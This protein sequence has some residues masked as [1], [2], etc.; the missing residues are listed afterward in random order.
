MIIG[1]LALT[2]TVSINT[3]VFEDVYIA[4]P[5]SKNANQAPEHYVNNSRG[6][7]P[8]YNEPM[9]TSNLLFQP[10]FNIDVTKNSNS[11]NFSLSLDT[12]SRPY[13]VTNDKRSGNSFTNVGLMIA[14]VTYNLNG[15]VDTVIYSDPYTLAQAP[16]NLDIT[17]MISQS[18]L[19]TNYNSLS[20]KTT[21]PTRLREWV[22][23]H[24]VIFD[25]STNIG[26]T[27]KGSMLLSQSKRLFEGKT[28]F[29]FTQ[30]GTTYGNTF[31]ATSWND[32]IN[33]GNKYVLSNRDSEFSTRM[34]NYCNSLSSIARS[35]EV[36]SEIEDESL[37]F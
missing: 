12:K 7:R 6:G 13:V 15:V 11:A 26:L 23:V 20:D 37:A 29:R 28:N 34:L 27:Q 2:G 8:V 10:E 36:E 4:T 14:V 1:E 22:R 35:S 3:P 24:Y 17:S 16:K 30:N 33:L 9:G 32:D 18:T 5:G 21:M 31:P 25:L 19:N